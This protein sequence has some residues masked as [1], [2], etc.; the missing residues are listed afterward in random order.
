M[1]SLNTDIS[2][3][4]NLYLKYTLDKRLP[5]QME[6]NAWAWMLAYQL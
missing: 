4:D 1:T 5:K 2:S 6:M 3:R